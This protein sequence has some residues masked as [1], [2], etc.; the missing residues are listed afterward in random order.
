MERAGF[1]T[2]PSAS[3]NEKVIV[4]EYIVDVRDTSGNLTS[5]TLEA[6]A[7]PCP[8]SVPITGTM[9][10]VKAAVVLT[11]ATVADAYGV[12]VTAPAGTATGTAAAV[13]IE[14]QSDG[15]THAGNYAI[16]VAGGLVDLGPD[17]SAAGG[18]S[19]TTCAGDIAAAVLVEKNRAEAAEVAL[20]VVAAPATA[21][22]P[23]TAGQIAYDATNI[24]V[25]VATN[26]WVRAALATF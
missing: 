8:G 24:Y 1:T 10:A 11:G 2:T 13:F 3:A 7:K 12:H 19:A 6:V 16:K 26:T 17:Y 9:E 22:S 23:G 18:I 14:D 15:G 21:T 4:A 20:A 5:T 25:C